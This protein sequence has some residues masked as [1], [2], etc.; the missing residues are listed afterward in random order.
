MFNESQK[1]LIVEFFAKLGTEIESHDSKG[2]ASYRKIEADS[3]WSPDLDE[4]LPIVN[5]I[6]SENPEK[7]E[8]LKPLI[9]FYNSTP[10]SLNKGRNSLT[11]SLNSL[12]ERFEINRIPLVYTTTLMPKDKNYPPFVWNEIASVVSF[13][14]EDYGHID[15]I[16]ALTW[17]KKDGIIAVKSF[18]ILLLSPWSIVIKTV[19]EYKPKPT[20]TRSLVLVR[21]DLHKEYSSGDF[22]FYNDGSVRYQGEIIE[23]RQQLNMLAR[24]FI[25]GEK[26]IWNE[27]DV[28]DAVSTGDD[29]ASIQKPTVSKYVSALRQVL[30]KKSGKNHIL[31]HRESGWVFN[32]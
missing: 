32:P 21:E 9:D 23:M 8:L 18:S 13:Q 1:K 3:N 16:D 2:N 29:W 15:F 24:M 22:A 27:D 12:S 25:K 4:M 5:E 7:I 31:N 17:L 28:K 10:Y 30:K 26:S 19:L 11:K 6:L 14:Q 20:T